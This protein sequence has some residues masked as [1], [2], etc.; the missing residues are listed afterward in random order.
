MFVLR[1]AL[2]CI[3]LVTVCVALN[4]RTILQHTEPVNHIKGKVLDPAGDPIFGVEVVVFTHPELWLDESLS[5]VQRRERQKEVA[6]TTSDENGKF[7]LKRLPKGAYE[8][9]FSRGGFN[10]LSVIVTVDPSAPSEKFCVVLSISSGG[11]E[12]SF[13][14]CKRAKKGVKEEE[15]EGGPN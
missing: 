14:P 3:F 13:R 2:P 10:T 5:T 11:G 12:P 4:E 9:E 1:A 15:R 7:A 6:A 8:L